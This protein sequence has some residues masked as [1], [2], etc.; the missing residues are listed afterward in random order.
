MLPRILEPEVMDTASEADAYDRMDHHEVNRRFVDDLLVM[1]GPLP[2]GRFP[3]RCVD[4]GTGTAL[5]PIELCRRNLPIHVIAT[6][7]AEEMLIRARAN[8]Q[9]AG[10]GHMVELV[11]ADG[12]G[13]AGDPRLSPPF[14]LVISNSIVHHIPNPDDVF[15]EFVRL[16]APGAMLFVRDLLR[17]DSLAERDHLVRIHT[18]GATDEQRRLFAESL[19]AALTLAEVRQL[20]R[21]RGWPES[22]ASQTS[23]RHWTLTL[24]L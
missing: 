9:A 6:D 22:A 19:H 16:A 15:R 21:A 18:E 17:P 14:D 5:I 12:K 7:L 11:R 13:A 23:D 8:V 3:L 20:C 24:R 1:L 2:E 4:V 10:F